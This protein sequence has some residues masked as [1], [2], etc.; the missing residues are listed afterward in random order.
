MIKCPRH[1]LTIEWKFDLIEAL[2]AKLKITNEIHQS[3][4]IIESTLISFKN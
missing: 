3:Q 2:G 4:L 1:T